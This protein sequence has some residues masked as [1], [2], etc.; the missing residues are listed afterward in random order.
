MSATPS[1]GRA[2]LG[3]EELLA[4]ARSLPE[5]PLTEERQEEMRTAFL[6]TVRGLRSGARVRALAVR[7]RRRLLLIGAAVVACAGAA[8]AAWRIG[9]SHRRSPP[10]QPPTGA[11][12]AARAPRVT[13]PPPL[14]PAPSQLAPLSAVAV[15]ALPDRPV[16]ASHAR[17]LALGAHKPAGA[18]DGGDAAEVAFARGWSSLRTG[19]F[20]TAAEWFA[21]ATSGQ[22]DTLA[23]D[24]LFW[25]GVALDRAGR[26]A[27]AHRVLTDFLARYPDSDRRGEASVILGWLL[28]RSGELGAARQRF[29]GALD[30]PAERVRNSAHAGLVA[31]GKQSREAAPAAPLGPGDSLVP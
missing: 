5:P 26:F 8:A 22:H 7:R 28:V 18:L 11:I 19:D 13:L 12:A 3:D 27:V 4:L 30:D 9:A 17:R 29:E 16:P 24:A 31:A 20:N 25:Q 2:A 14:P 15:P 21:R 1:R 6:S 10:P 23:E